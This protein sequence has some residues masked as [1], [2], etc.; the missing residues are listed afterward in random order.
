MNI[1]NLKKELEEINQEEC[2]C[3]IASISFQANG[4]SIGVYHCERCNL[5]A[6]LIKILNKDNGKKI[7][8]ETIRLRKI[9]ENEMEVSKISKIHF[10]TKDK[11]YICHVGSISN[12][13]LKRTYDIQKVTCKKCLSMYSEMNK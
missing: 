13:K 6:S 11:K 2:T 3:K 12:N 7:E 8:N 1:E 10:S 9:W 4:H 5:I